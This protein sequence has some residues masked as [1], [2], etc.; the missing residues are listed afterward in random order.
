MRKADYASLAAIIRAEIDSLAVSKDDAE[1]RKR[2]QRH[3]TARDIAR[4]F[5]A[6]A[7]VNKEEFLAACG[8]DSL[9]Y[10]KIR[11]SASEPSPPESASQIPAVYRR[12]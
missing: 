10:Q 12:R 9:P 7:S 4:Q 3:N 11:K 5:A 1:W 2:R 6:V 8:V